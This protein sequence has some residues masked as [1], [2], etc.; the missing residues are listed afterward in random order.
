MGKNLKFVVM[1]FFVGASMGVVAG[2]S[3]IILGRILV[4]GFT[5]K[6]EALAF[7]GFTLLGAIIG[8]LDLIARLRALLQSRESK[9][10]DFR[11]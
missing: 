3:I 4:F 11:E 5:L 7:F 10:K 9:R 1:P 2:I 6:Q 8:L